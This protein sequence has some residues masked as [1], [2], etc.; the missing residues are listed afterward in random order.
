MRHPCRTIFGCPVSGIRG[1]GKNAAPPKLSSN[2]ERFLINTLNT[3]IDN[4]ARRTARVRKKHGTRAEE[5]RHACGRSTA[6]VRK[7]HGTRTEG[8]TAHVRKKHGTRV[9]HRN[10]RKTILFYTSIHYTSIFTSLMERIG[11]K[12][13]RFHQEVNRLKRKTF[14]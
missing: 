4:S 3:L 10:C 7:K 5:A 9:I 2:F 8:S 13:S 1:R 12:A 6:H 11:L 14:R